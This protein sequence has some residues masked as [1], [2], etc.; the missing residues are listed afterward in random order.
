LVGGYVLVHVFKDI[1][2]L[3]H[4]KRKFSTASLLNELS[5]RLFPRGEGRSGRDGLGFLDMHLATCKS[6]TNF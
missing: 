4:V 6:G 1:G 5:Q 3:S 2:L